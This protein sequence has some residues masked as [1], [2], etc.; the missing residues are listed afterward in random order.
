MTGFVAFLT[1]LLSSEKVVDV[2]LEAIRK[3]GGLDGMDAQ[4]KADYV[5]AYIAATKHQSITR[6]LIAMVMVL[7]FALLCLLWTVAAAVGYYLDVTV[8]LE[9]AGAV[10]HFLETVLMT[11][12]NIV[13]GFYFI[14]NIAQKVGRG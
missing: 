14:V 13:L 7:L 8:S 12:F 3:A 1:G 6:R 10:R 9:L 2:G 11:P 4:A 5:L